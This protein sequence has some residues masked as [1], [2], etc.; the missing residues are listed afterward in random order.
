MRRWSDRRKLVEL[1]LFPGYVFVRLVP[2]AS[3]KVSVLRLNGVLEFVGA[4]GNGT[5]NED[6]EIES[7]RSILSSDV[8][9]S[10]IG[11]L[12]IGQR[13]RIRGGSLDGGEGTLAECGRRLVVSI[14]A[15]QRSLAVTLDGFAVEPL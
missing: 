3:N 12:R 7:V 9:I 1:P 8:P 6:S 4:N 5:A 15:I 11:Y 2:T 14:N 10:H 13:V